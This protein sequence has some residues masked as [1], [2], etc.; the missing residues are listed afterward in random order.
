MVT[1]W[2]SPSLLGGRATFCGIEDDDNDPRWCRVVFLVISQISGSLSRR[3]FGGGCFEVSFRPGAAVCLGPSSLVVVV[4]AVVCKTDL[5]NEDDA[6]LCDLGTL[7]IGGE[8]CRGD[9]EDEEGPRLLDEGP[10][11]GTC[12]AG[13][14]VQ[15]GETICASSSSVS[16]AATVICSIK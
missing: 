11:G 6:G 8:R 2:A 12:S 16:V 1:V 13:G 15:G 14:G 5:G 9:S 7:G 4:V 10:C 3:A